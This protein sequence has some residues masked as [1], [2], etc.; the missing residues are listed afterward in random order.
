MQVLCGHIWKPT[1]EKSQTNATNVILHPRMQALWEHIWKLTVEKSQTN[2]TIVTL[3]LHGQNSWQYTWKSMLQRDS[4]MVWKWKLLFDKCIKVNV[5]HYASQLKSVKHIQL[6]FVKFW[7]PVPY[8]NSDNLNENV[9]WKR[10]GKS[11]SS[12]TFWSISVLACITINQIKVEM[13]KVKNVSL[14][15]KQI[16]FV[17]FKATAVAQISNTAHCNYHKWKMKV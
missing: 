5:Q 17:K 7:C 6:K 9:K 10:K 3:P 11:S 13:L 2:A 4:K 14:S 8:P 16:K 12:L 15:E 1:V